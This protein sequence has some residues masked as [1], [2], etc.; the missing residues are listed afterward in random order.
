MKKSLFALAA[1]GALAGVAQAQSSVTVYGIIDEGLTGGNNRSTTGGAVNTTAGVM[2]TT[3]FGLVQSGQS[4]SRLG[5]KGVEDLGGGMSAL[6]TYETSL[7]PASST[8]IGTTRQ[9]FVGIKKNGIGSLLAGSQN[10]TIYDAVLASDPSGVNNFAGNLVTTGVVGA[11]SQAGSSTNIQNTYGLASNIGYNTRVAN[12]L[13]FK[14]DQ[15]AGFTARAMVIGALN[16]STQTGTGGAGAGAGGAKNVSG[17]GLGVDYSWTKLNLTANYQQYRAVSNA[18][19]ASTSAIMFGVGTDSN[20]GSS[21][22]TG[23]NVIDAGTYLAANY[24]FGILKAYYQWINRK[25]TQ[26]NNS[27][28]YTK[29]TANQ[30][31]VNAFVTPTIQ[32]WASAAIGKYQPSALFN[33]NSSIYAPGTTNLTAFQIGSNYFLSKRTNLYAIYGQ[34]AQSNQAMTQGYN[35]SAYNI[36]NYGVGVRHTF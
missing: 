1:V 9:A 18:N 36:N 32:V 22:A 7:A 8:L 21:V 13:Q 15:F 31:G 3:G 11:Q 26:A 33:G 28:Y 25:A 16:N 17:A 6:F 5:F 24:D 23:T 14:S 35:P 29:Y 10:T 27:I 30:I 20:V 19:A 12:A 34:A 2:K 4:T